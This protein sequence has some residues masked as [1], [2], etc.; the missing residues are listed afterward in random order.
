MSTAAPFTERIDQV[1]SRVSTKLKEHS[2]RLL[3]V[4]QSLVSRGGGGPGGFSDKSLGEMIVESENFQL[5]KKGQKES[6]TA[7]A[8][9]R[10]F[11]HKHFDTAITIELSTRTL[12]QRFNETK[13]AQSTVISCPESGQACDNLGFSGELRQRSSSVNLLYRYGKRTNHLQTRDKLKARFR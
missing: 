1:H 8:R 12:A 2:A 4:E 3:A 10:R 6:G 5:L 7:P 9:P 11:F 13:A